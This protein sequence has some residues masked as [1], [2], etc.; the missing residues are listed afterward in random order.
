MKDDFE[1]KIKKRVLQI[2]FFIF[3]KLMK[4][5]SKDA[6]RYFEAIYRNN[7]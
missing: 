1:G 5:L 2:L 6:A 7:S 3:Q 4:N